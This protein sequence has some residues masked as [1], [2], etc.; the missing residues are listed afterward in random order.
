MYIEKNIRCTVQL[1][2]HL[3]IITSFDNKNVYC[4][5]RNL[6]VKHVCMKL[7]G[8]SVF[9]MYARNLQW[10]GTRKHA[11]TKNVFRFE[12]ILKSFQIETICTCIVVLYVINHF[13][14]CMFFLI[15]IVKHY[16]FHEF[17]ISNVRES[18][19]ARGWEN[20]RITTLQ[21]TELQFRG[22]GLTFDYMTVVV[23]AFWHPHAKCC[24]F[25]PRCE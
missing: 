16:S 23:L 18:F 19:I 14:F 22:C 2:T 15:I 5:A 17:C 25:M 13:F 20:R 10:N 9:I 1:I 6:R 12:E 4:A 8:L 24:T 11:I 3:I 7:V 21:V